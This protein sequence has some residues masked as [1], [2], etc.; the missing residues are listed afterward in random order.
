MN[1]RLVFRAAVAMGMARAACAQQ[2]MLPPVRHL[3]RRLATSADTF[4]NIAGIRQLSD[5]RVIVNDNGANRLLLLDSSLRHPVVV[6]DST[7]TT[8]K[9]YG[10]VPG[11]IIGYRGDTTLFVDPLALSMQVIDPRGAIVRSVAPPRP[12]DA[13][14][15]TEGNT[16]VDAARRIVYEYVNGSC[17]P[18]VGCFSGF[19]MKPPDTSK[20]TVPTWALHDS[21]VI[22]RGD[23]ASHVTDTAGFIA[24][25]YAGDHK[26]MRNSDGSSTETITLP[27]PI[28]SWDGWA[29]TTDGSVA[30]VRGSDY[31]IDWVNADGTRSST[32]RVSHEWHR[33]S[34]SEKTALIDSAKRANDSLEVIDAARQAKRDSATKADGGVVRPRSAVVFV[35]PDLSQVSDYRPAVQSRAVRADAD[36]NL[37]IRQ[38]GSAYEPTGPATPAVYD[39]VNRQGRLI[40]RV[41]LPPQMQI[42][43]FGPGVVYLTIREG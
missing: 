18:G 13:F 14:A 21:V 23:I 6:A 34:D 29:V 4:G 11:G 12:R 28:P 5:G 2:A 1:T 10:D 35:A 26:V 41:Q 33:L 38:G 7:A 25:P 37:W 31:H 27:D 19:T 39:I 24:T 40:D 8:K 43:G 32:P 3:G 9:A 22:L 42:G 30:F 36:N 16:A 17:M 20:S 15:M